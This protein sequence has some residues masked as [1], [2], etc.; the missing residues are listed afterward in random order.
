MNTNFPL[1]MTVKY[2]T[3]ALAYASA[4]VIGGTINPASSRTVCREDYLGRTVC[5]TD[6]GR[7]TMSED[8]LDRTVITGPNGDRT[9]CSE[10]YLGR[11]V[12][13]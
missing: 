2:I 8:Y 5:D 10:D 3:F 9:V 12:C 7:Y 11:T 1:P 6:N 13:N 4:L